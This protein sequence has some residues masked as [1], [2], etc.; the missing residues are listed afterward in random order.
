M[1]KPPS[2]GKK[3][4]AKIFAKVNGEVSRVEVCHVDNNVFEVFT[5]PLLYGDAE[6]ALA[7]PTECSP[8]RRNGAQTI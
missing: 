6:T 4:G 3:P 1:L 2:D 7:D 8:Y 5:F